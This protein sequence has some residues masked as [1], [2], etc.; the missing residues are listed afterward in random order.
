[1]FGAGVCGPTLAFWLSRNGMRSVV[2]ERAP[3]L[4]ATGQTIDIRG[5]GLEV[6]RRMGLEN[7]IRS[8]TTHEQGL[9]FVDASNRKR[10]VFLVDPDSKHQSLIADIEI[11]RDELIKILYETTLECR[12]VEYVFDDYPTSFKDHDDRVEVGFRKGAVREFDVVVGADEMSSKT[13]RLVFNEQASFRSVGQCTSYFTIPYHELDG[14]WARF[15]NAPGGHGIGLRPDNLGTAR[16]FLV[17]A[18]NSTEG[19]E[20]LGVEK[21]RR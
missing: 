5:A 16:A 8:R 20:K 15:Y 12:D 17:V 19:Y 6:V 1:L 14:N 2:V 3:D 10:A 7:I 9:A 13:R 18:S 4:C 21:K 11:L